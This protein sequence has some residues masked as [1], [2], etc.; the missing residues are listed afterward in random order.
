MRKKIFLFAV[1]LCGL[2]EM[3]AAKELAFKLSAG[4]SWI[5]GGDLNATIAGWRRYFQDRQSPYFSATYTL[6]EMH[7]FPEIRAELNYCLSSRWSV[8]IEALWQMQRTKGDIRA[9]LKKDET[10]PLS[11]S[12]TISISRQETSSKKASFTLESI[13]VMITV[14]YSL[15][16]NG[17]FWVDFG[18]SGGMAWS[19]LNYGEDYEYDFHYT[20]E[21]LGPGVSFQ[22]VERFHSAGGYAEKTRSR[23]PCFSA[24]LAFRFKLRSSLFFVA[25]LFGRWVDLKSWQGEK[26]DSFEWRQIW[27]PWGAFSERGESEETSPGRLWRVDV[28]SEETGRAYPRLVFSEEK[29][30]SSSYLSV[31]PA[32]INLSG[33]GLR[34]GFSYRFGQ[35]I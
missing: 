7:A 17:K 5:D 15:P 14:E 30:T 24:S 34:M 25:E 1:G 32:R 16:V 22:Y 23:G 11:P 21:E 3:S 6:E 33:L 29:P 13:P 4:G 10:T 31:R 19:K 18:V 12:G 20:R 9:Q 26:T 35:R 2:V 8:G 27:G 28:R